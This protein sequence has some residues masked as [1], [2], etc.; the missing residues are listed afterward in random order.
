MRHV[1]VIAKVHR[2]NS[3]VAVEI[4]VVLTEFGPL[5]SLFDYFMEMQVQRSY[6]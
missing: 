5:K 6:S 3:G 4:P 2:D 1:T